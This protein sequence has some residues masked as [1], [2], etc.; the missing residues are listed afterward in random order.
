MQRATSAAKIADSSE[1]RLFAALQSL[2]SAYA[3]AVKASARWPVAEINIF[4]L[5]TPVFHPL[6]SGGGFL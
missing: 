4:T 2:S 5:I 6:A 3:F 1:S